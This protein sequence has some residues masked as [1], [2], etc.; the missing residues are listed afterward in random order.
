VLLERAE[1]SGAIAEVEAF[2]RAGMAQSLDPKL[3]H[4]RVLLGREVLLGARHTQARDGSV[5]AVTWDHAL[6]DMR[7]TMLLMRAWAAAYEDSRHEPPAAISDRDVYLREHIPDP[8]A[9]RSAVRLTSW[10]TVARSTGWLLRP[11][12]CV[13][14]EYSP[15]T[16]QVVQGAV[17]GFDMVLPYANV[18]RQF[19]DAQV[20]A[21][22]QR[23]NESSRP[24]QRP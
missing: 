24:G 5:L 12:T 23:L 2:T 9:A 19:F 10:S 7:T 4:L 20:A 6:G 8:P 21:I 17:H 16:L 14:L 11:G 22:A 18:S 1:S 13:N 15:T 3:S